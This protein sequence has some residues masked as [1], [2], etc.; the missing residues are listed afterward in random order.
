MSS[1]VQA[2]D[3]EPRGVAA[4]VPRERLSA[5]AIRAQVE[6]VLATR[7]PAALTPMARPAPE[8]VASG[9]PEIDALTGGLPRG[10]LTEL[11]GPASSGRTST[12]LAM[13]AASTARG[14]Y[15]C[16]VDTSD[17]F[18]PASAAA[19]GVDL[20]RVLWI[21]CGKNPPRSHRGTEGI[22]NF[23][24]RISNGRAVH[25]VATSAAQL[26]IQNSKF[27]I[28]GGRPKA[29]DGSE[30]RNEKRETFRLVEQAL[31]ITDLVLQGG[32]F[33][34]VAVDLADIPPHVAR[35]VPLTSWFRFRRAVENT[36][37]AL[38]V[39]EQQANA[40]TCASLV[41]QMSAVS[42]QLSV[43]PVHTHSLTG[44][45]IRAEAVRMP[46]RKQPRSAR[47]EFGTTAQWEIA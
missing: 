43:G 10:G 45:N 1:S 9:V 27:K 6:G 11:C 17:A 8:M 12:L 2:V 41:L 38:V 33:G 37:T 36:P 22:S 46:G 13:L 31:K 29:N 26:K 20:G 24:F 25:D 32:G 23:E 21:R 44:L 15:C 16:L 30:T 28:S 5:A 47:A 39:V 42:S 18:D 3:F 35:R 7:V 40:A 34:V 19:A 4:P 14:E